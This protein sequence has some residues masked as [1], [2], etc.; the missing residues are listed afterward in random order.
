MSKTGFYRFPWV[1]VDGSERNS[2]MSAVGDKMADEDGGKGW[3]GRSTITIKI[4]IKKLGEGY[5]YPP[6]SVRPLGPL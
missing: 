6:R 5:M 3:E 4:K 1:S 2:H